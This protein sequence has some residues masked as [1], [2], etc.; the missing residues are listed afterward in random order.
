MYLKVI[1]S[2]LGDSFKEKQIF[3]G[4]LLKNDPVCQS[5]ISFGKITLFSLFPNR[6][7]TEENIL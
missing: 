6:S 5:L 1:L 2:G 3:P 4:T 7:V